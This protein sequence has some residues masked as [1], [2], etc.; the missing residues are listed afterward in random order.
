M[1]RMYMY[2]THNIHITHQL[3]FVSTNVGMIVSPL[4]TLLLSIKFYSNFNACFVL[5]D[6][7]KSD[8]NMTI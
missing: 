6:I 8:D 5:L 3:H 2:H 4:Q 7:Y 1:L